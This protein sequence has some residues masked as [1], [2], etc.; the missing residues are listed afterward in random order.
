VPLTFRQAALQD[1]PS[2]AELV[3]SAYRG[4]AS[5]TGWT[6]EADLLGGQRTDPVTLREQLTASDGVLLLAEQAEA[7]RGCVYLE[8]KHPEAYLGMLTIDPTRQ[9]SGLG[10]ALLAHAET[11]A[12]QE[13]NARA[14]RMTV[15]A[16]RAELIA[17]YARRGYLPT[18][19]REAFPYGD[20]RFGRPKR[21]DL[22]FTILR[23][24]LSD[25]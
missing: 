25:G 21:E 7:L 8:R 4:D 15:I 3:N 17:W 10:R 19:E 23:K 22:Y 12:R 24:P 13:W 1:L 14:I 20:A 6:T 5:R 2:I 11:F 16:Q 18:G 9:N